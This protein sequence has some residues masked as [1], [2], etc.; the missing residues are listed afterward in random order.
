MST[1]VEK[2]VNGIRHDILNGNLRPGEALKQVELANR[3]GVSPIPLR[4][5]LQRLQT[6]GLAVYLP[7]RGALVSRLSKSE[8]TDIVAIRNSLESLALRIAVP[9]ITE[10]Q[11]G[12]LERVV[13]ALEGDVPPAP[14]QWMNHAL[15]FYAIL[16]AHAN[17]PLLLSMI[18]SNIKRSILYYAQILKHMPESGARPP[19]WRSL[20]TA[21]SARDAEQA[22]LM[23][24]ARTEAY[25]GLFLK[26]AE[27]D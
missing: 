13:H 27:V 22:I 3:Y 21:I 6:E 1:L 18:Q 15:D 19:G 20:L 8:A 10:Q 14:A 25:L 9:N 11:C 5:A 26:H 12:H 23:L 24:E 16:L 2:I 4:E 17:R 7:Y